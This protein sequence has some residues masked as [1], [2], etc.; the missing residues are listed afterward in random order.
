MKTKYNNID[1]EFG[2]LVR[3]AYPQTVDILI[4]NFH[5]RIQLPNARHQL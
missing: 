4:L 2:I 3:D 1:F 5:I